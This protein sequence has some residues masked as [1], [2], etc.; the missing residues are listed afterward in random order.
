MKRD[1]G[2]KKATQTPATPSRCRRTREARSRHKG[3][4]GPLHITHLGVLV[5]DLGSLRAAGDL[6]GS[7]GVEMGR[8][9]MWA[10]D[11]C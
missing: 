9:V 11:Q 5:P 4:P 2:H 8:T 7:H 10:G 1:K 3:P 6:T